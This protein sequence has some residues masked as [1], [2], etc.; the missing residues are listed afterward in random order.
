MNKKALALIVG[1]LVILVAIFYFIFI[2]DF[3]GQKNQTP[4]DTT[5]TQ[6]N[7]PATPVVTKSA[8]VTRTAEKRTE[9]DQSRDNATQLAIFFAERYG[10]SSSQ[11]D[12][13]NL[14]DSQ[15]FM[16]DS[17]ASAT[18]KFI[19]TERNK[20]TDGSYKSIVTKAAVVDFTSYNET[21]GTAEGVVKTKRLK[22]ETDGKTSSYD[23]NLAISLK[24]VGTEWK[25]DS[26]T[27]K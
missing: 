18:S 6:Q 22:T 7:G 16:T 14:T 8:P 5:S 19:A 12:F 9:A 13:S 20:A 23:Q 11:A 27:W 2:Y 4:T 1:G 17:L 3:S 21:A 25:V 26:V 10:T 15:V 24:K